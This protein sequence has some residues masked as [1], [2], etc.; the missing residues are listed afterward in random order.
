MRDSQDRDVAI[1]LCLCI[2]GGNIFYY[3]LQNAIWEAIKLSADLNV[4]Y[5]AASAVWSGRF[6]QLYNADY[7]YI[8]SKVVGPYNYLPFLSI[9]LSPFTTLPFTLW[10]FVWLGLNQII[11]IAAVSLVWR[12]IPNRSIWFFLGLMLICMF[13]GPH[14]AN[15]HWANVNA[16]IWFC[17]ISGWWLYKKNRPIL[18]GAILALGA[19]I[20]LSP[21]LI[22][23]YFLYRRA[24]KVV[25]AAGGISI[26]FLLFSMLILGGY[27]YHILWYQEQALALNAGLGKG[28]APFNQS[29]FGF[30]NRL[31]DQHFIDA[32]LVR[33]YTTVS[34]LVM[35]VG[36]FAIC[37]FKKLTSDDRSFD[38]EY[39]LVACLPILLSSIAITPHYT[40]VLTSLMILVLFI[41][42]SNIYHPILFGCL[43][44]SFG[45]MSFGAFGGASFSSG[46]LILMQ[47]PKLYG[48]LILWGVIWYLLYHIRYSEDIT[49]SQVES[50]DRV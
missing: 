16:I 10:K 47:S 24:Y 46:I 19:I 17:M 38:L 4:Y 33:T 45:L 12:N 42:K 28:T 37:Q 29:F 21:I 36:T 1:T 50:S 44:C 9:I 31:S 5:S 20:K 40:I 7:Y 3:Y 23:G 27:D 32:S 13:Y 43:A 35:L 25:L 41:V 6:D 49:L 18:C 14:I 48:L 30:Y 34:S 11:L 15:T 2:I 26:L 8:E 39:A 22:I